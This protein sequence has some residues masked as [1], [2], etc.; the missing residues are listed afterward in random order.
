MKRKLAFA[1]NAA[2]RFDYPLA[3][4]VIGMV[5]GPIAESS[6]RR[7]LLISDTGHWIL[8]ERP[9]SA[10][11]LSLCAILI[12]YSSISH[13]GRG[14][15]LH[16]I[17]KFNRDELWFSKDIGFTRFG[18][19]TNTLVHL[20]TRSAVGMTAEQ[21]AEKVRCRCQLVLVRLCRQGKL[22]RQ[23]QGH[24]YV[25]LAIDP[26]IATHQRQATQDE[27]PAPL[28]GKDGSLNHSCKPAAEQIK[29]NIVTIVKNLSTWFN[30]ASIINNPAL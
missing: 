8:V 6:Y 9:I 24:S 5:F 11:I 14:Y 13:N 27:P 4:V 20:T 21:L 26:S 19:L 30:Y 28:V 3:P 29:L 22:Q 23:K 18:S 10:I 12:L 16:T 2:H 17:P 25:Y 1:F 7:A 15:T